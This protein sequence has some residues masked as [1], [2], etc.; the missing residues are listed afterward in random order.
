MTVPEASQV[1]ILSR[2]LFHCTIVTCS[3][4]E[5][6]RE[7]ERGREGEREREREGERERE[8]ERERGREGER[9][10]ERERERRGGVNYLLIS[11]AVAF[12]PMNQKLFYTQQPNLFLPI[13]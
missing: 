2:C 13:S 1:A 10:R 3:E 8:R 5:R 11:K 12:C 9:E 6:G 7:R 4:F